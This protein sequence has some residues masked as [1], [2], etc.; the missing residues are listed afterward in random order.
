VRLNFGHPWSPKIDDAL[1][2]LGE[3]LARPS[4][5]AKTGQA[6]SPISLPG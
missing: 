1:R 2:V 5:R 6:N 3:L 4:V